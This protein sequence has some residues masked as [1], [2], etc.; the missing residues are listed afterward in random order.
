MGE[1]ASS[2]ILKA[3]V[4]SAKVDSS[5]GSANEGLVDAK[6]NA[7]DNSFTPR[8]DWDVVVIAMKKED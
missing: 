1:L 4:I 5:W 7:W 3:S 6:S 2:A 8:V